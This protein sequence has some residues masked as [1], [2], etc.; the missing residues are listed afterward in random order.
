MNTY[1]STYVSHERHKPQPKPPRVKSSCCCSS[2]CLNPELWSVSKLTQLL[3][4][5]LLTPLLLQVCTGC[6]G[7]HLLTRDSP[8]T[9]S[10]SHSQR[11]WVCRR[12]SPG[13]C[14]GPLLGLFH[15][16][17]IFMTQRRF[18]RQKIKT[19]I[20]ED[21]KWKDPLF[22]KL[23]TRRLWEEQAIKPNKRLT[24]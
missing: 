19:Q 4:P 5:L 8:S 10:H 21:V 23:E 6:T 24:R 17:Y 3:Q 13:R 12:D 20:S 16:I 22:H 2:C 7:P 18:T 14:S 11:M 9:Q 1:S 15:H